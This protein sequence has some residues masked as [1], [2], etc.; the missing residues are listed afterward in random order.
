MYAIRSYYDLGLAGRWLFGEYGAADNL[1][2]PVFEAP[3][4]GRVVGDRLH[5]AVAPGLELP[6][7]DAVVL[8]QVL[9]DRHR[10]LLR[11]LLVVGLLADAVGM[12]G[13]EDVGDAG[14]VLD[15]LGG[16]LQLRLELGLD[17]RLVEVEV[18]VQRQFQLAPRL[19]D[20]DP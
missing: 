5:F 15:E 2:P 20:D 11:K 13:D 4:L 12:A 18:D 10:P 14:V 7:A 3:F 8:D 16:L 17:L 1:H 19:V 9:H 6:G